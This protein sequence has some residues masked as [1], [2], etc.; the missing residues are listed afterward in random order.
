[1]DKLERTG[2]VH[3]E[4]SDKEWAR[5]GSTQ[6]MKS[7]YNTSTG[8]TT[9]ALLARGSIVKLVTRATCLS[10]LVVLSNLTNEF[11]ECFV[12]VY[13]LLR[14]GL[15]EPAVEMGC[16]LSTLVHPDLTFV[17]Q[18]TLICDDDDGE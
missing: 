18:I 12:H 11:D 2:C 13:A 5:R 17:L 6:M 4:K 15:N 8:T 16:E 1:M 9:R 7:E 14:R 3:V 10:Q